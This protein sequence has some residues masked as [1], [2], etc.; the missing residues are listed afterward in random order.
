MA[1][2]SM[3]D[4]IEFEGLYIDNN[5]NFGDLKGVLNFFAKEFFGNNVQTR[6]RHSQRRAR[7][8]ENPRLYNP[9]LSL[10]GKE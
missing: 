6:F 3:L 4:F 1:S 5:V 2:K 8:P 7:G 10:G 9:N